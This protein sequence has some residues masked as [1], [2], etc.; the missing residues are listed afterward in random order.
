MSTTKSQ[1]KGSENN[2]TGRQ[3]DTSE[4]LDSNYFAIAHMKD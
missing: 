2:G 3:Q 4:R 1:K